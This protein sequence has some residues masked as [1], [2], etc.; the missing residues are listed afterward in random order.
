MS[1]QFFTLEQRRE[2][3]RSETLSHLS[4][5]VR[6]KDLHAKTRECCEDSRVKESKFV[7][8]YQG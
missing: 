4:D 1:E 6:G 8:E 2:G 7:G 3:M 5:Q